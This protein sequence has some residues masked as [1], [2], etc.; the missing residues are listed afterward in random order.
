MYPTGQRAVENAPLKA[1]AKEAKVKLLDVGLEGLH[2]VDR[3]L[4]LFDYLADALDER[5]RERT[6]SLVVKVGP[7]VLGGSSG[8]AIVAFA[9]RLFQ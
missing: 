2:E 4:V 5:A 7:W 8:G 3:E 1:R 6:P 9:Q